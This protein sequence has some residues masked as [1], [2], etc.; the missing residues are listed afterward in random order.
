MNGRYPGYDVLA[1]RRTPSWNEKTRRVIDERLA[2][3]REPRFFTTAEFQTLEAI[4]DRIV[5]QPPSRPPV[6]IAALIDTKLFENKADGYRDTRL[7]P[8]GEAWQNGLAALDAE[9]RRTKHAGFHT[10]DTAEQE[11]LLRAAQA[12]HLKGVA[13]HGMDSKLFFAKR[14]LFDVVTTYYGHPTAWSE[15]GYGG[16]ASPRGYVRMGFDRRDP[17]EA[18][19]AKP[20]DEDKAAKINARIG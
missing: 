14:L 12:G 7:P 8:M 20:G 1:K 5:P 2:V 17:W 13:W 6:P 11:A 3:P 18:A 10:L 4:C 16:P 19:E 9:A 15:I